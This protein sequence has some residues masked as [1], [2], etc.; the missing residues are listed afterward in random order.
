MKKILPTF[1]IAT[2][3]IATSCGKKQQ[4]TLSGLS[5]S[6]TYQT[7]FEQGETFNYDG[8]IVS[9][10]YSDNSTSVVSNYLI[11]NPD[12]STSGV[13]TV[14]LT[15]E[16]NSKTAETSYSVIVKESSEIIVKSLSLGG[17]PKLDYIQ[18]DEFTSEGLIV[19]ALYSNGTSKVITNYTCSNPD[20]NIVGNQTI[21]VTYVEN[22]VTVKTTYEIEIAEKEAPASLT[23]LSLTLSCKTSFKIGDEFSHNGL[24][25]YAN[26]SNGTEKDVTSSVTYSTPNM[27]QV[28]QQNIV[29]TYVEDGITVTASYK[30]T[31]TE[32]EPINELCSLV[33]T[34]VYKVEF[35]LESSFDYE[36][37][38]VMAV[39]SDGSQKQVTG[40]N[41]SQPDLSTTGTK[42][43]TVTYSEGS[44]SVHSNYNITVVGSVDEEAI[45]QGKSDIR[46]AFDNL[47][48]DDYT[49]IRWKLI[50]DKLNESLKALDL[51][52]SE[53]GVRI[54]VQNTINF[55][56][57][58]PTIDSISKG[59]WFDYMSSEA[60]Y[61]PDR[62]E[63]GNLTISYDGNPGHWVS[64]GTRQNLNT[65][66]TQNN[67]LVLTFRNEISE[68]IQVCLQATD[69]SG[70]YKLD[71]GV[72]N[73]KGN[74]TKTLVL[75]Y[76]INICK[77][78]FF[79]DSC[80][81]NHNR[82]GKVT[83]LE[84]KLEYEKRD[85]I[86]VQD[87]VK[88]EINGE[89][90]KTDN[91]ATEYTL[92]DSDNPYYI[93][94][95]SALVEVNFNGN[96]DSGK[97]FGLNLN[98]N[99][100]KAS[101]SSNEGYAQDIKNDQSVTIG[102]RYIF[103]LPISSKLA[104]GQ[105]ISVGV[106]YAAGPTE[107]HP[108]FKDLTF[109]VIS[110]TFYYGLWK[111]LET[112]KVDVNQEIYKDGSGKDSSSNVLT[113]TIPYSSFEKKGRVSKMTV[114][115]TTV[116]MESYGK[117]QIY[118]TNFAFT[119][120]TSGNNNVLDVGKQMDT[121]KSGVE[122]S[123]SI[124][125]YPTSTINLKEEKDITIVCWWASAKYVR[126]DSVIMTTDNVEP[127]SSISN[128]ES[129][130]IDSGVVLT[131]TAGEN[132]SQYEVYVDDELKQ[133]IST[134]YTTIEGLQNGV[135]HT[136]KI[137]AKNSSGSADPVSVTGKAVEGATYDMF[138]EGLNTEFEQ[139][140]G[141]EKV[142]KVLTGSNYW[143]QSSNN[144][145]LKKA[146]AKMENGE[147]TTV[148]Y[149]G[150]SITVG[151]GSGQYVDG[152]TRHQKGYA[153]YSYEWMKRTFDK[154]NK[155]HFINGSICGTGSEIGLVRAKKD[156][157]NYNPDIIFIEFAANNGST[158]FDDSSYESLIRMCMKQENDPAIILVFSFT[159]YTNFE[160]GTEKRLAD[161]GSYYHLPMFSLSRGMMEICSNPVSA[162]PIFLKFTD[163][164]THPNNNGYQLYGKALAY[165]IRTLYQRD[166]DEHFSYPTAP[167]KAN[168][169]RFDS[170]ISIDSE[171]NNEVI[172]SLG[173]FV[174]TDTSTPA[175]SKQSDV[176]AFQKGWKKTDTTVNEPL[177]LKVNAKNFIVINEAGNPSVTGDPSGNIVVTYVNDDDP[178]DT[179]TLTWDV[180]KTCKQNTSNSMEVTG[181][182]KGWENPCG[183]RVL[184]KL[185]AGNYTITIKMDDVTGIC[186]IF[187]LGYSK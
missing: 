142:G 26:Y 109:K 98:A 100:N 46:E 135:E 14:T 180:A 47:D 157:L 153:Y 181:K 61:V 62:D 65:D 134:T 8:L 39:Y 44:I 115:F 143:A 19:T 79:L 182:D 111:N 141:A 58:V 140:L 148:A 48:I 138:I 117:S 83:I 107:T 156:I 42:P 161:I 168:Y 67:K 108:E 53:Q 165:F 103:N 179:G 172:T 131:W 95:V 145:R 77:L 2:A 160:S 90:T 22:G 129:H 78:Y 69:S 110:Y 72:V 105:T 127:P 81:D 63:D 76:D 88:V 99:S 119:N 5:L 29:V 32:E 92:K 56:D 30:I 25:A 1:L 123:G 96:G 104:S 167:S 9:A 124:D 154:E 147:E 80:D 35:I 152:D 132:T 73:V 60:N 164:G 68:Q 136:F 185:E 173:S 12:M 122:T 3:L 187:A 41:V 178:T 17:S 10:I 169:D 146:L 64:I 27:N 23:S 37:L 112:E 71:T 6:G 93:E 128:L 139:E 31:I 84:T 133:T 18:G 13:K 137:V 4:K 91:S 74:E 113:A 176:T 116:N 177:T 45:E 16:E 34:G 20:M 174:A 89:M 87:P 163:D 57:T 171:T 155:S 184:D 151:E 125:L 15:Y 114:N 101:L 159:D 75:S 149:M 86:I 97:Y 28:G 144:E 118:F 166:V 162:D 24:T 38:I 11:S 186:T 66:T 130:S 49:E 102:G 40:F 7:I 120:F 126:I 158:E 121:T 183:I 175:V 52:L 85:P 94:R 150:G 21:E 170:L 59:T 106:S 33:L 54:I 43:V 51:S 70:A 36:G 82:C 50:I 55:F